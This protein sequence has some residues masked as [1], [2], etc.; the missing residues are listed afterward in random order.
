MS[1]NQRDK[2]TKIHYGILTVI[3]L[4]VFII[5]LLPLLF[6]CQTDGMERN[7]GGNITDGELNLSQDT[8][9]EDDREQSGKRLK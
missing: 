1:T 7:T 4:G 8:A 9:L 3:L 2:K 6:S 5:S